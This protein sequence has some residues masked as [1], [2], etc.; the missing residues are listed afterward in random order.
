MFK[1]IATF[2]A[3]AV[4]FALYSLYERT[5]K[6]TESAPVSS[7]TKTP[8]SSQNPQPTSTSALYKDGTYTG[9]PGDALYGMIQVQIVVNGGKLTDVTFLQ[10]P[11][12]RSRSIEINTQAM[13]LL[14]QEAIQSQSGTVDVISGAT[15][16]SLAFIQSLTSALNNARTS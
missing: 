3:V 16:T 12:D 9:N 11:N 13:P 2:M 6:T 14:K 5:P 10:Y 4:T 1:K 15:D 8:S 7:P